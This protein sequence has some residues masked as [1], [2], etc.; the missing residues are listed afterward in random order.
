MDSQAAANLVKMVIFG[1]STISEHH[2]SSSTLF[3]HANA[4]GAQAIGAAFYLETPA[5]G[6]DPAQLEPYSSAGGTPILFAANGTRLATPLLRN[7]PE[8]TAVDGVNTTFF[9]NDSYGNDGIDDFFGTS[10]AAPHAAAIAAL[11]LEASPG[12]TDT[13]VRSALANSALDMPPIS[14]AK[15][16]HDSGYGLLQASAAISALG[17]TPPPPPPTENEPPAAAFSYSCQ[18]QVCQ[19]N[20]SLSTDDVGIASFSWNFGDGNGS[21]EANPEHNYAATGSYTV[22]LTVEDAEQASDSISTSFRVKRRGES[23]GTVGGGDTGG[24]D[25][26]AE[27]EKGRKKCRDGIDNDLDGLTDL[28]DPDCQR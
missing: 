12:A 24:G 10:A 27:A 26:V 23:S 14:A 1:S 22:S 19:F 28:D 13:K 3:G 8:Y 2:T 7:K 21:D 9:F 17:S 11:M 20:G 6:V 25:P 18:G 15:F 5:Y 4:A 16:D